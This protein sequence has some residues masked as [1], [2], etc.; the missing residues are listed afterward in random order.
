MSSKDRYSAILDCPNNI[1]IGL[2]F[3]EKTESLVF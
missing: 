2:Y 1:G 3:E